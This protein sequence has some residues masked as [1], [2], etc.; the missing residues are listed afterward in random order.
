MTLRVTLFNNNIGKQ[1]Q[2]RIT[3]NKCDKNVY[4]VQLTI[5]LNVPIGND[6]DQLMHCPNYNQLLKLVN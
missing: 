5:C 3:V 6:N 2:T 1:F 4:G